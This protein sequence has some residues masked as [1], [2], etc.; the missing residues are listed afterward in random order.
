MGQFGRDVQTTRESRDQIGESG[1]QARP[2][3]RPNYNDRL[4]TPLSNSNEDVETPFLIP[5]SSSEKTNGG[6]SSD[7]ETVS[8]TLSPGDTITS[9]NWSS[10]YNMPKEIFSQIALEPPYVINNSKEPAST[11]L[12]PAIA[13]H[14]NINKKNNTEPDSSGLPAKIWTQVRISFYFCLAFTYHY[15]A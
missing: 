8:I 5:S 10:S 2:D 6:S 1:D 4:E 13:S 9:Q 3:S 12:I 7:D 15:S 11:L 14:E